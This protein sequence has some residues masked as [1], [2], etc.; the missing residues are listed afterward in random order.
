MEENKIR[1]GRNKHRKK[2]DRRSKLA[3]E[4]IEGY[5]FSEGSFSKNSENVK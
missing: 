2:V 3:I 4:R 5:N 1:K